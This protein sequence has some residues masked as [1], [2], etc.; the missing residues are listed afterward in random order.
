MATDLKSNPYDSALLEN[1]NKQLLGNQTFLFSEN[2]KLQEDVHRLSVQLEQLRKTT[3]NPELF[4]TLQR[5]KENLEVLNDTLKEKIKHLKSPPAPLDEVEIQKERKEHYKLFKYVDEIEH[6]LKNIGKSSD[7]LNVKA[8]EENITDTIGILTRKLD[9]E[10]RRREDANEVLR[11]LRDDD[12][13][14]VLRDKITDMKQLVTDLEVENTKL[15]FE[16]EQLTEDVDQYKKQVFEL[17]EDAKTA[18]R[19]SRELED[20]K[21]RLKQIISNLENDNL[22]LKKEMIV[23][24]NEANRAKRVS[25]DTEL[26]LQHISEAYESKRQE[27]MQVR[28]QLED[29]EKNYKK[30]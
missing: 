18:M 1:A 3:V 5:E 22:Q 4:E 20:E 8:P 29:A 28:E 2:Q 23:E 19:R 30:F 13:K 10:Q 9:Q 26:A 6:L 14:Y 21:D 25:I 17:S 12:E 7:R 16:C 27:V 15:K 24:L 11:K